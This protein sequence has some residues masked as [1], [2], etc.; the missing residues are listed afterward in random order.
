MKMLR[1]ELR[2]LVRVLRMIL[3]MSQILSL[4]MELS[5]DIDQEV[6]RIIALL[7]SKPILG[8]IE[9]ENDR[10]PIATESP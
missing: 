1:N 2:I 4:A 9:M 8:V 7:S 6:W 5:Y 3:L 10:K